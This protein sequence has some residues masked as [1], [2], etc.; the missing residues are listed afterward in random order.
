VFFKQGGRDLNDFIEYIAKHATE[1]LKGYDRKGKPK[2]KEE[3]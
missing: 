1:E 3:L 2:K